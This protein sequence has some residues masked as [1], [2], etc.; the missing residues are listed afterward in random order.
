MKRSNILS[1]AAFVARVSSSLYNEG[2][3]NHTCVLQ[4]SVESCSAGAN[5]DS[6]DTCCTETY[7]GV[8][9][10]IQA[11]STYTGLEDMDQLLP[12]DAWTIHG[13]WPSRW[14]VILLKAMS[15][16]NVRSTDLRDIATAPYPSTATS[17]VSMI[18]AHLPIPP[19]TARSYHH[20]PANTS[21]PGSMPARM[22]FSSI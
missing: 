15:S 3:R 7:G 6:V 12:A 2:D 5:P 4:P 21:N 18:F 1:L 13:L 20:T 9:L 16:F 22:T 14:Y 10:L 11:W 19:R 17:A 8:L